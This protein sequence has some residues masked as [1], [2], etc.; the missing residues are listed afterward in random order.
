VIVLDEPPGRDLIKVVDFG[1][2]KSLT[3]EESGSTQTGLVVGTP[4]YLA[5]EAATG[6]RATPA[7]DLYALGVIL[8]ELT[9]GKVLWQSTSFAQLIGQKLQGS[10][11]VSEV[12]I[13]LRDLVDQL[14]APDPLFRP[15]SASAVRAV[16]AGLV[17][18]PGS[19][20]PTGA[21][22]IAKAATPKPNVGTPT[23]VAKK[24][25]STS[26]VVGDAATEALP[27][28]SAAVAPA[29]PSVVTVAAPAKRR[30]A[31][32]IALGVIAVALGTIWV[33]TR[34]GDAKPAAPAEPKT[35]DPA[36]MAAPAAVDAG[37]VEVAPP[38]AAVTVPAVDP[39]EP[40]P[41]PPKKK[42]RGKGKGNRDGRPDRKT[43]F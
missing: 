24:P 39:V 15:A 26:N 9:T 35:A 8:A 28:T 42:D 19:N 2:A 37:V 20:V 43:P 27:S 33:A 6:S 4:R 38:D 31:P 5:P 17:D 36:P 13:E 21:R 22:R 41:P 29:A 25:S 3:S 40:P 11:V 34:G 30:K 16:L 12:P 7:V 14:I 23:V 18:D 32:W 10:P 1:L